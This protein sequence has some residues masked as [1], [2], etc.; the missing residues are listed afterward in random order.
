MKAILLLTTLLCACLYSSISAKEIYGEQTW[1]LIEDHNSNGWA[2]PG[3][4]IL[5][6]IHITLYSLNG[7]KVTVENLFDDKQLSLISGS[8]ISTKGQ[9]K[10]GNNP[11]DSNLLIEDIELGSPWESTTVSFEAIITESSSLHPTSIIN[12]TDLSTSFD[13]ITTNQV[14]IP[15]L[16][17][18]TESTSSLFSN[19]NIVLLLLLLLGILSGIVYNRIRIPK[20]SY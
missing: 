5:N 18:Y 15:L 14:N 19:P 13:K 2:D 7:E 8:V 6:V 17:N 10:I 3:D 12:A 1:E 16:N 20:L 9:I 11:K 4:K